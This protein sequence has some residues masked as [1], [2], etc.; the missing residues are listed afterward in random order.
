M[1][2]LF[3]TAELGTQILGSY[4]WGMK[5]LEQNRVCST[6]K[7]LS[8]VALKR[9]LAS[10]APLPSSLSPPC[11]LSTTH[12]IKTPAVQCEGDGGA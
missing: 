4:I 3:A 7:Q 12:Y 1:T 10:L 2:C 6:K 8:E 5:Q 9:T 11:S